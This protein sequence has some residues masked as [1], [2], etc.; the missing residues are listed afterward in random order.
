MNGAIRSSIGIIRPF[1]SSSWLLTGMTGGTAQARVT[2]LSPQENA[3][4]YGVVRI[5]VKNLNNP[6]ARVSVNVGGL[7]STF[8]TIAYTDRNSPVAGEG[9]AID[10]RVPHSLPVGASSIVVSL[11]GI[12]L[13]PFAVN[14]PTANPFAVFTLDTGGKFVAELRIDK[15][16]GT[17]INFAGLALGVGSWLNPVTGLQTRDPLYDGTKF[18]R[19]IAGFVRQGGDPYTKF[20]QIDPSLWGQGGPGYTINYE[21]SGLLHEDGALAMARSTSLNSGGSQFYIC[22]GAQPFL[23]GSYCVFGKVI[24]NLAVA[25]GITV[26]QLSNG[27]PIAGRV[28]TVLTSVRISGKLALN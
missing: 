27:T 22:D 24:E 19:A 21:A 16:R 13:A 18:H 23:N 14:V 15:A 12:A 1:V 26:N 28:P 6:L 10:F 25:K 7:T 2:S 20:P 8:A 11:N 17:V 3:D 5:R 9:G 4:L